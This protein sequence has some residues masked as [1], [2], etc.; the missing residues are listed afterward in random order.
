MNGTL[1]PFNP[2]APNLHE[3]SR[4][5][6]ARV[7]RTASSSMSGASIPS[8]TDFDAIVTYSDESE[9]YEADYSERGK[10]I[11]TFLFGCD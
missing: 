1:D 10:L 5:K 7:T 11:D 8:E 4:L 2:N 9:D 3:K 6:I